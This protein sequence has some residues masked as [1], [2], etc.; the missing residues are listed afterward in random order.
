MSRMDLTLLYKRLFRGSH[1]LNQAVVAG[2][3]LHLMLSKVAWGCVQAA[4]QG[5]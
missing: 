3:L 5:I 1:L 4:S 2:S